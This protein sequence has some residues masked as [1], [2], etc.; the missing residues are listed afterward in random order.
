M[1]GLGFI[2]AYPLTYIFFSSNPELIEFTCHAFRLFVLSFLLSG[3]NIFGSS[4]FTA[5]NNGLVSANSSELKNVTRFTEELKNS[6]PRLR[7]AALHGKMKAKDKDKKE[8][9]ENEMKNYNI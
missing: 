4:F 1:T 6:L 8:N 2:L 7:I 5:L 3:F 9:N